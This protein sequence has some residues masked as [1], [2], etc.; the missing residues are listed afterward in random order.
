MTDKATLNL[1]RTSPKK[2]EKAITL[3]IRDYF[4]MLAEF[5]K[6]A[7]KG[8]PSP[9][10]ESAIFFRLPS[11]DIFFSELR[12]EFGSSSASL[13]QEPGWAL[14]ASTMDRLFRYYIQEARRRENRVQ[15]K[16]AQYAFLT[17]LWILAGYGI[18][19]QKLGKWILIVL[20]FFTVP[21]LSMI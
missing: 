12:L 3:A 21:I 11:D 8:L 2:T 18:Q 1:Y 10:Q 16:Y 5:Y 6:S 15:G 4:A 9:L 19:P 7:R 14:H 17:L 13:A 20:S